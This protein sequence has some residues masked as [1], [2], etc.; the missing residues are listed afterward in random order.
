MKSVTVM[1]E[2]KAYYTTEKKHVFFT[3]LFCF[4]E[5]ISDSK[6]WNSTSKSSIQETD[7]NEYSIKNK[8]RERKF[9]EYKNQSY[10]RFR[11]RDL[12]IQ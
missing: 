9:N 3:Y 6:N 4:K 11:R 2:R 8:I 5:T 1:A 10:Y 12:D 7:M